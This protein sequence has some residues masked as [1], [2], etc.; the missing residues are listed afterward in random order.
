MLCD[1]LS[2][3]QSDLTQSK[4]CELQMSSTIDEQVVWL[5]ITYEEN[6]QISLNC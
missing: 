2:T 6:D 4:V 5:K 1:G 3:K